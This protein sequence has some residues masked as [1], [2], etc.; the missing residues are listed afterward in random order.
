MHAA[1][2]ESSIPFARMVAESG[3]RRSAELV[4]CRLARTELH[5]LF[6]CPRAPSCDG[7]GVLRKATRLFMVKRDA[8][9]MCAR[10]RTTFL[11]C[12][13]AMDLSVGSRV[14]ARNLKA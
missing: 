8:R 9:G 7:A 12:S 10:V 2:Q 6:T 5:T 1:C 14:S 3:V 11:S 4:K 13:M